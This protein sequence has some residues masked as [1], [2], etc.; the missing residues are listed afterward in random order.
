MK[1]VDRD[2]YKTIH[3]DIEEVKRLCR[4]G[5]GADTCIW[6]VV[7]GEGFEC[8]Y[9]HKDAESLVG[10]TLVE[11]W[12]KGLTVAKR[13]GCDEVRKLLLDVTTPI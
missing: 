4:P 6:L 5:E 2:G 9:Y 10:D 13:D 11:R 12:R 3:L 7:G 1:I 8:L